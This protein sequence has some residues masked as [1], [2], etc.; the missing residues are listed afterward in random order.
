MDRYDA[1]MMSSRLA[2]AAGAAVFALYGAGLYVEQNLAG[3]GC[4]GLTWPSPDPAQAE[5]LMARADPKGTNSAIQRRAAE[6]VLAARPMESSAW[7]RLAYADR[8][9]H[10]RLTDEGRHA[11]DM[12]YLVLPY[13]GAGTPWRLTFVL[14]NWTQITPQGR[15]DALHEIDVLKRDYYIFYATRSAVQQV[16]NPAGRMVIVLLGLNR[17]CAL[18][19]D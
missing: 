18:C 11:V 6:A 15:Q 1:R 12:S 5:R 2:L 4:C 3:T 19:A 7:L 8:I 10:G 17:K 13:A 14:D 9:E 16:L